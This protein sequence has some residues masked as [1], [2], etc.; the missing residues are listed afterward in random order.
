M[1][2]GGQ[3]AEAQGHMETALLSYV[4]AA[5]HASDALCIFARG[6]F[7]QGDDHVHAVKLLAQVPDGP[8]LSK[9]LVT[10]LDVKKRF[11]YDVAEPGRR[12]LTR[13]RRAAAALVDAAGA[14]V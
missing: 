10:A 14:R 9:H 3:A 13:L 12:E 11:T 5:I 2:D 1:L 6:E 4:N 7:A 8:T